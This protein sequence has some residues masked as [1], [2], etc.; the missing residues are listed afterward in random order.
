MTLVETAKVMAIL[1][2][3]YR[4][5]YKDIPPDE[6]EAIVRIW[7][8]MFAD[9]DV[10]T[11][12]ASVR[13]FIAGD[14]KGFP[15]VIGQIKDRMIRFRRQGGMTEM[16]AWRL[17][18]K[19]ISN[20]AYNS[21]EEFDKLPTEIRRIVGNHQMFHEW[22]QLDSSDIQTVISS[23]FQRSYRARAVHESEMLALPEALRDI[24]NR[25][26]EKMALPENC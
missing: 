1:K 5:Y 14:T 7:A 16:E 24:I 17:V 2:A 19:A 15:P 23:N 26:G 21:Q 9:D 10:I 6:V 18:S 3:A 13:A 25:I 8:E 20:S 4:S 12:V 11:V 22:S